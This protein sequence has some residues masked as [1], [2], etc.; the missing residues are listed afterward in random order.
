M[1]TCP[2]AA[3][4]KMAIRPRKTSL[5]S[6]RQLKAIKKTSIDRRKR[7]HDVIIHEA[8]Q[9]QERLLK[10]MMDDGTA[11]HLREW[12]EMSGDLYEGGAR[13]RTYNDINNLCRK[14]HVVRMNPKGLQGKG[15]VATYHAVNE[16]GKGGVIVVLE[17]KKSIACQRQERLLETMNYYGCVYPPKKWMSLTGCLYSGRSRQTAVNDL[18]SLCKRGLA[19]R[20][21]KGASEGGKHDKSA[22][23]A[24]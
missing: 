22:Y 16:D 19:K 17:P 11:R 12:V 8:C 14:G 13:S 7:K 21:F 3:A 10:V 5:R 23:Q 2:F 24:I 4:V 6:G 15:Y 18:R 20:I 1:T 9:R